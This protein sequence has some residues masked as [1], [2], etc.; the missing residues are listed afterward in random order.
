[1]RSCGN[2]SDI[3]NKLTLA[4]VYSVIGYYL[5]RRPEIEDYLQRERRQAESVQKQNESRFDPH[6]I[7]DR[8][9]A[10]SAEKAR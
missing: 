9:L 1:M 8:L 4:D 6:G 5:R 10:R 7:R 3:F 2:V